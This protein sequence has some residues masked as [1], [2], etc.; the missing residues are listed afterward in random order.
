KTF[1]VE[2]EKMELPANGLFGYINF[3]AVQHF[4]NIRFTLKKEEAYKIPEVKYCFYKYV[5]AIDHHK[6][7]LHMLENLMENETPQLDYIHHLLINLNF[8]NG[9]F[10]TVDDETSNI[11][12]EEYKHM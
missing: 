9:N 2:V 7:Q 6:N 10:N 8:S 4:E 1:D 5:V 12:D 3:D 11:T